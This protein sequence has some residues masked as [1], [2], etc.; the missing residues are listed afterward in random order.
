MRLAISNLKE[1][2]VMI[3]ILVSAAR[4]QHGV[5][6][7]VY[8]RYDIIFIHF[9]STFIVTLSLTGTLVNSKNFVLIKNC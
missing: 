6:Q 4:N 5:L 3:I 1:I 8:V 7:E 9:K 2:L